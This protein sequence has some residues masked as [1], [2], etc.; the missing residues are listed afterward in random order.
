[1]S[2][3]DYSFR[4]SVIPEFC[5][6]AGLVARYESTGYF[7]MLMILP[8]YDLVTLYEFNPYYPTLLDQCNYI[9]QN[10]ELYWL[11]VEVEGS[12]IR[13]KIWTG[14]PDDEP[15]D[16]QLTGSN[17]NQLNAGSIGLRCSKSA[18]DVDLCV[19]FDDVEVTDELS[20]ELTSRTWGTI[21]TLF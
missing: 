9:I 16:F 7:F 1:M 17:I 18:T 19:Y 15:F 21:K 5:S 2:V 11:R 3:T 8:E 6:W 14:T 20:S 10:D 12:E 4:A 13:G